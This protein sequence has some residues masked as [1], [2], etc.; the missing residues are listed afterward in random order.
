MSWNQSPF[1]SNIEK[2]IAY[3]RLTI[4]HTDSQIIHPNMMEQF[5]V[6]SKSWLYWS[7][8]K[9]KRNISIP[10]N[11]S[12]SSVSWLRSSSQVTR[13]QSPRESPCECYPTTFMRYSPMC[14]TAANAPNT[15]PLRSPSQCVYKLSRKLLRT[16]LEAVNYLMKRHATDQAIAEHETAILRYTQPVN[17]PVQQYADYLVA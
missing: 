13:T 4:E 9:W 6:T 14:F 12:P 2:H 8:H 11:Q 17:R 10:K 7:S 1:T 3:R 16:Y 5:S 15:E